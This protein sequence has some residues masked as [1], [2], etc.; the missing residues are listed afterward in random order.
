MTKCKG[1]SLVELWSKLNQD[2]K[3][4]IA[5][6]LGMILRKIH[7]I[8]FKDL[9]FLKQYPFSDQTYLSMTLLME[10]KLME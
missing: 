5:K 3:I 2:K 4:N 8:K 10:L 7:L 9:T 6:N 1:F